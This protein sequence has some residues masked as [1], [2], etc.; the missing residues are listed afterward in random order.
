MEYVLEF[1]AGRKTVQSTVAKSLGNASHRL[2]KPLAGVYG[3]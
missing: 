2:G 3:L 1:S